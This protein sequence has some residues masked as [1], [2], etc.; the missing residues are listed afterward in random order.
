MGLLAGLAQAQEEGTL[1]YFNADWSPDG[2]KIAFESGF[3]DE[4]S[5]FT[6]D[7]NGQNLT[8]LTSTEYNDERP[9][10]SPDGTKI[11][12]FSHRGERRNE[13]PISLQIYSM[14]A[15]GS[16]QRRIT[17]EGPNMD[18]NISWSPNGDQ[19]VFQSRPEVNPGDHSLYIIGVDGLGRERLTDARNNDVQPQW[20]P[21]GKLILFLRSAAIHKF[22]QDYTD[23]DVQ[24]SNSSAQ[25]MTFNLA[26]GT[27]TPVSQNEGLDMDSNWNEEGAG[28][29]NFN[30]IDPTWNAHGSEVYYFHQ[31]DGKKTL[32]RRKLGQSNAVFVADG[33]LVSNSSFVTATRLSP[34]GRFLAYHKEINGHYGIYIYDLE[35]KHERLLVGGAPSE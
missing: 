14:N 12:F 11:A 23:D 28:P 6:I 10:W 8:S 33:D 1:Y 16:G 24:L 30:A 34:D 13:Q 25:I 2:E 7:I 31:V 27:T 26:D 5:I 18:Y 15:D 4:L 17:H 9:V 29:W 3:Q 22:Y 21:D 32:L 35:T 19:L 20:S